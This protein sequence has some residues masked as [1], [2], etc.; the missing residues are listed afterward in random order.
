MEKLKGTSYLHKNFLCLY[1][2]NKKK[3]KKEN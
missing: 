1:P 3:K 2:K